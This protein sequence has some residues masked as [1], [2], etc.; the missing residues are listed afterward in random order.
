L[1]SGGVKAGY[2]EGRLRTLKGGAMKGGAL[3]SGAIKGGALVH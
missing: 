3:K 2:S 1:K